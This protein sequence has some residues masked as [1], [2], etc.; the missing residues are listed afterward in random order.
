VNKIKS[1]T[2]LL[3]S[4]IFL[5][6]ILTIKGLPGNLHPNGTGAN[7]IKMNTPPF[8]T[9]MERGRFAQVVALAETGNLKVNSFTRFLEPDLA[10]YNNNFYS[11]F[12]PGVA[13]I[14]LPFYLLGR[15]FNL[16]QIFTF[17]T[18]AVFTTITAY[19]IYLCCQMQNISN[20]SSVLAA[21]IFAFT[22]STWAYSV[23][24]SAHAVSAFTIALGY[25]TLQKIAKSEK[26][27]WC[28]A[29]MGA[30]FGACFFVDY[31]NIL[32][33]LPLLIYALAQKMFVFREEE[34][35]NVL[36][37]QI[38]KGLG[39]LVLVF[40][41][42]FALFATFNLRTFHKPIAFT[43]TYS[44]KFL[45]NP[46]ES[47]DKMHLN[48]DIFETRNYSHRFSLD[49]TLDGINTLTFSKDRGLF[50]Y[51]PIYL[52]AFLG[53]VLMVRKN[54]RLA[55]LAVTGLITFLLNLVIYASYDDPWGGWAF[56]PRYLTTTLPILAIFVAEGIEFLFTKGKFL[57]KTLIFTV[58]IYCFT[59]AL[60]GALTTNAVPPSVE[61]VG[62]KMKD[63]FMF[64]WDYL[65]N[66]GVNSFIYKLLL[67][68]V[69]SPVWYAST[70]L[71]ILSFATGFVIFKKTPNKSQSNSN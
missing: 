7:R 47:F 6:F 10:W 22:S 17:L 16:S 39:Y 38:P 44:I 11:T 5:I 52:L 13:F 56:G 14:A 46:K 57:A 41:L 69:M 1:P 71:V 24:L 58:L 60:L 48:N 26:E 18:S 50:F 25:F 2:F 42:F 40:S 36:E 23:S 55:G 3:I 67:A 68:K 61:A 32:I 34:K 33:F 70:I 54:R 66:S 45:Q 15:L 35:D 12:P 64:N 28:F 30:L 65:R 4:F 27:F 37:I 21:L 62:L 8:E 49:S 51:A 63:N 53:L 20:R 29:L 9:S 59:V 43:N 19:I 31:P